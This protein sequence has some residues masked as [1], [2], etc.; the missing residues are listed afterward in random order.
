MST[1]LDIGLPPISTARDA[2]H[3]EAGMGLLGRISNWPVAI[4][5]GLLLGL[6]A[7]FGWVDYVTGFE[8]S[9][10]L[11]YLIPISLASWIIG[12]SAGILV[13][14]TSA[15]VWFAAD[16]LARHTY[17]HWFLP[18]WNT[19]TLAISFVVVAVLIGSLKIVNEGLEQTV[20]T[21][22]K[23]LRAEITQ[24]RQAE[25]ELTQA[26]SDARN[27]HAQ[28]QHAQFKLIEAAKAESAAQLATGVAHEVK[29][30]LMTLGLGV[31]YLLI[32]KSDSPEEQQLVQDMKEAVQRASGV[33]NVLLDYSRPRPLKL[34]CEDIHSVIENS[35]ALVRHQLNKH[36]V[37]VERDFDTAL[38]P[39]MLDRTRIEHVFVN[40]FLN[41][42]EAMPPGGVLTV[43]TFAADLC[44]GDIGT[45][46]GITVMVED[47]GH[48][49]MPENMGKLFGPFFTTKPP[50]QGTGLG[51]V[52]ARKI[53]ELHGGSIVLCNRSQ[54]GAA[55]TL[56]LDT[57]PENQ[58]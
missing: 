15:C 42:I 50:G 40:L 30:P 23:A 41:A 24:R 56:K 29:N 8:V 7:V 45:S 5:L 31:D 52:V 35:L 44:S 2:F 33:I 57:K 49:I 3:Q 26:L 39:M 14:L 27:A 12:R 4:T 54:G 1:P 21:R 10:S 20:A 25:L 9:V 28:L 48:G 19:L 46:T 17:G 16:L 32:R 34:A 53:M 36:Q 51:L 47:T 22:T 13:A 38:P 6:A 18:A 58:P 11:L 55:A 37:S 43:R